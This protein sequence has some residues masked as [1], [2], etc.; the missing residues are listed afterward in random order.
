[1]PLATVAPRDFGT[2]ALAHSL[3]P[4]TLGGRAIAVS[5][6]KASSEH[7]REQGAGGIVYITKIV[8]R[9]VM[10]LCFLPLADC[11][12][13]ETTSMYGTTSVSFQPLRSE[14]S[15]VGCTLVY[16]AV[17]ADF[18][19]REGSP[20]LVLGNIGVHLQQERLV[21]AL[22]IGVNDLEGPK[23]SFVA[24][25]FAYLQTKDATTAELPHESDDSG[26]GFSLFVVAFGGASTNLITEMLGSGRVTIG[27]NRKRGGL[28]VMIPV[29]LTVSSSEFTEN[30]RLRQ[31]HTSEAPGAF[32]QCLAVLIDQNLR[33]RQK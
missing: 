9:V 1:M 8:G 21:I 32:A 29:D 4:E 5:F 30:G 23:L 15:L 27:F 14:G 7:R 28:D 11:I 18:A 31:R 25:H 10:A 33:Q 12:A 22:K 26:D 2:L 17:A 6:T 16:Q 24:P 19:Y 13:Q 3:A 20:I